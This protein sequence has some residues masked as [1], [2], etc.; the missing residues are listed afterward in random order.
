[1][2]EYKGN[3]LQK[4]LMFSKQEKEQEKC[5][6][7]IDLQTYVFGQC[8]VAMHVWNI[9]GISM[10]NI[11]RILVDVGPSVGFKLPRIYRII[12]WPEKNICHALHLNYNTGVGW[13]LLIL[14]MGERSVGDHMIIEQPLY[15]SLQT[16]M[17]FPLV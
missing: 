14:K 12:I 11:S 8:A 10:E 15:F 13:S 9:D 5:S 6:L 2:R 16:H 4:S 7:N 1:M 3:R 17:I